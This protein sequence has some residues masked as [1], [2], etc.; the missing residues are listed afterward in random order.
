MRA[1]L[2]GLAGF[3]EAQAGELYV[4]DSTDGKIDRIDPR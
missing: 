3:G 1:A 2:S 4:C